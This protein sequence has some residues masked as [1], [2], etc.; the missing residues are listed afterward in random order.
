MIANLSFLDLGVFNDFPELV[1][2]GNDAV[3]QHKA[4]SKYAYV[5]L[6]NFAEQCL[7]LIAAREKLDLPET[8]KRSDN[9]GSI[10]NALEN[11]RSAIYE[12]VQPLLDSMLWVRNTQVAHSS[13][14]SRRTKKLSNEEIL[15]RL[16]H[17]LERARQVA[18][19]LLKNYAITT[20]PQPSANNHSPHD[21][22]R[23]NSS[24]APRSSPFN[25]EFVARK[26]P[27][28]QSKSSEQSGGPIFRP[29]PPREYWHQ[30]LKAVLVLLLALFGVGMIWRQA[31]DSPVAP[32]LSTAPLTSPEK[33]AAAPPA[34]R[35]TFL[36]EITSI[37]VGQEF[38]NGAIVGEA[39]TF[40]GPAPSIALVA[41]YRNIQTR[42]EYSAELVVPGYRAH[43]QCGPAP[44]QYRSGI[45][46]CQ[47]H[48][49]P[50]G[51]YE[52]VVYMAG[53]SARKSISVVSALP[54]SMP[55]PRPRA[56]QRDLGISTTSSESPSPHA[57]RPPPTP[58]IP[59]PNV[60]F[61]IQDFAIASA[62]VYADE[63]ST[64][65]FVVQNQNPYP[66]NVLMRDIYAGPCSARQDTQLSISPYS[67]QQGTISIPS[68]KCNYGMFYAYSNVSV[69]TSVAVSANGNT[70]SMMLNATAA[71]HHGPDHGGY[72]IQ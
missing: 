28:P 10:L 70:R 69:N 24:D 65:T 49:I 3:E 12:K 2:F 47:W 19:W 30:E 6:G 31:T 8:E 63:S 45:I 33:H 35:L 62:A 27:P 67:S 7:R 66:I 13:S 50:I 42:S 29:P 71:F 1:E 23:F 64:I 44:I 46:F 4:R 9:S 57:T 26:S 22:R 40:D 60:T 18:D 25:F 36:P 55:K 38:S 17:D 21:T 11:Q 61:E 54:V 59:I 51:E 56:R 53:I 20:R 16:P 39:S 43:Y 37:Q 34:P 32:P 52:A 14:H 15:N 72:Y 58:E 68:A 5:A 41:N 48:D